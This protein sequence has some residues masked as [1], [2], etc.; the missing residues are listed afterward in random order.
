MTGKTAVET[1]SQVN[2]YVKLGQFFINL[3]LLKL[4]TIQNFMLNIFY[5]IEQ[6]YLRKRLPS[7]K[8]F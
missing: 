1:N 5:F 6:I 4:Q 2:K 7:K 3:K 8:V